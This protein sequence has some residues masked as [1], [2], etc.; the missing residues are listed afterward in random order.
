VED[1]DAEVAQ[2]CIG[3]TQTT[4][5][6]VVLPNTLDS[7][8]SRS[9]QSKT[10]D[11]RK[12]DGSPLPNALTDLSPKKASSAP[13]G[14]LVQSGLLSPTS[15]GG[16][17]P[18]RSPKIPKMMSA[19]GKNGPSASSNMFD[20]S[21]TVLD[22]GGI[23]SQILMGDP[24]DLVTPHEDPDPGELDRAETILMHGA[25]K[26]SLFGDEDGLHVLSPIASGP[27]SPNHAKQWHDSDT[28]R[29]TLRKPANGSL[30]TIPSLHDHISPYKY[31][32]SELQKEQAERGVTIRAPQITESDSDSPDPEEVEKKLDETL[33]L[34]KKEPTPPP[35]ADEHIVV[36]EWN[37]AAMI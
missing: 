34:A 23:T 18:N 22:H 2:E 1:A 14:R 12:N 13:T 17:S 4:S 36:T 31:R 3:G 11:E 37:T 32:T 7:S 29:D 33:G 6:V 8:K 26:A 30:S 19:F 9:R 10:S 25:S 27:I 28:L 15:V 21:A 5:P 20:S 24:S 16:R 35:P